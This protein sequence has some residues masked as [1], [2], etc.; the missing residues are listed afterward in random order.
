[1]HINPLGGVC[2]L[3][4]SLRTK[5][6]NKIHLSP[7]EQEKADGNTRGEFSGTETWEVT[8]WVINKI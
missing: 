6:T 3:G 4:R 7:G 2:S 8:S 1:M 5:L